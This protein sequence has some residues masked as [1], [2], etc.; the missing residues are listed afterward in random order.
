MRISVFSAISSLLL[1]LLTGAFAAALYI[2]AEQLEQN[3]QSA[4]VYQQQKEAINVGLYRTVQAYLQSGD[5]SLL[6]DAEEQIDTIQTE[7]ARFDKQMIAATSDALTAL[8]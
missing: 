5:A 4:Q 1:L 6:T 2:S 3:E 7:L 8:S